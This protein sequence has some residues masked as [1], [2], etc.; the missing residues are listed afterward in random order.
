M[1]NEMQKEEHAIDST[2]AR[3]YI[4]RLSAGFIRTFSEWEERERETLS[5]LS[6]E[7]SFTSSRFLENSRLLKRLDLKKR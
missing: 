2:A 4:P 1:F 5:D 6:A 3:K 7:I